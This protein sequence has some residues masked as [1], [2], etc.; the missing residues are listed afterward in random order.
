MTPNDLVQISITIVTL[1][2][3]WAIYGYANHLLIIRKV[4]REKFPPLYEDYLQNIPTYKMLTKD[5]KEKLKPLIWQFILEKEFIGIKKEVT[6]EI[7]TV[8]AFFACLMVVN[9]KDNNLSVLNTVV[10]YPYEFI[11]NE[12]K[13][14]DGIATKYKSVLEG[15]AK[16]GVVLISWH[17]AKKEAYHLKKHNVVVH[18]MAHQLDFENGVADG[19]P[20]LE[21]SKYRQW[22]NILYKDYKKLSAISL[23]NRDWGKYKILGNYAA[24]N[25]AEF[26]AVISELFFERPG[27]LQANF[28][29]I[30]EELKSFYNLDTAE[31]IKS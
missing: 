10:V 5:L 30:Y 1:F 4:N 31:F 24:T 19:I 9:R 16:K 20:V 13:D 12:V 25:Q 22:C 28:P 27:S 2:V 6:P 23:K 8:I 14:Y 7:E 15:Q 18:E 11:Y 21:D 29:D 26:F 3:L 17:N